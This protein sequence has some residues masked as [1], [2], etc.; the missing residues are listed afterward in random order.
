MESVDHCIVTSAY[1]IAHVGG[2]WPQDM[3]VLRFSICGRADRS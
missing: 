1:G 2:A 3:G